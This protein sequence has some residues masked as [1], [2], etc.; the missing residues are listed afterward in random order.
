[1]TKSHEPT[2]L[3]LGPCIQVTHFH[4]Q[5][6]ALKGTGV[7]LQLDSAFEVW[8]QSVHSTHKSQAEAL[9]VHVLQM[10]GRG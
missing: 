6:Q 2:V 4:L 10:E 5:P 9:N 3:F 8:R 7:G 1:M